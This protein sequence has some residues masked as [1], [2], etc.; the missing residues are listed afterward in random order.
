[1]TVFFDKNAIMEKDEDLEKENEEMNFE[2]LN[3]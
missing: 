3:K 2:V 1:M